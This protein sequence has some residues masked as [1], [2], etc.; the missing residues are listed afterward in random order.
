MLQSFA[1]QLGQ[2]LG[3][4]GGFLTLWDEK[5]GK[6]IPGAAY[7][8][9]QINYKDIDIPAEEQTLTKAVL[10]SEEVLVIEDVRTTPH[11]SL[12]LATLFSTKSALV[13]P[14]IA[15]NQK[16]GAALISFDKPH[17]FSQNEIELGERA[18]QQIALA[19]LK[20]RLLTEARNRAREAE[21]LR[22]AS[23]AVVATLN[24]EEAIERILEELNKVVP[25]DSASVQLIDDGDLVIV[26]ERGFEPHTVY[27]VRFHLTSDTPNALVFERKE[28]Y[29]IADAPKKYAAFQQPPHDHIRGWLGVPLKV[30]DEMIGMLA[31]DS[32]QPG[33]FTPAHARLAQA[34]ADQVAIALE[35][36]RLFG[37]T[38]RLAIHDP[39]TDLYNRRHFMDL[40]RKEFRRAKRYKTPISVIMLDI[41][42]FK[43]VNDTFG[44]AVGDEVLQAV[45]QICKD[46]L[47]TS[48]EIGRY[49][50]EE[51][52]I[53]LPETRAQKNKAPNL[54]SLEPAQAVAERLR[55]TVEN[56]L[57]ST[58]RGDIQVT[59]S[60]GLAELNGQS[61]NVETLIDFADQ[62]LL[63]AKQS[64]RNQVVIWDY[65]SLK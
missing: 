38:Q 7:G 57:I 47:R 13:L 54:D 21:T 64:G 39:L 11:I 34:F 63:I 32:T 19:I 65:Q 62:A 2:L 1:D 52:V 10:E 61:K 46:N 37:E 12:R 17:K 14:L 15:N 4:D 3:A 49:G 41:D 56:N 59:I 25:Y 40:A 29:I 6:T 9:Y 27:G 30:H 18:A 22:Q 43:K 58:D 20:S 45:A 60:I 42:H 35:N 48:D 16:L 51:F 28:H 23:A 33:T 44:H 26:G 53:I 5:T 8:D 55:I 24:Q 50:G 31:L 36:S